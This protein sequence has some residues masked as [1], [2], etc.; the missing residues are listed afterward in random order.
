MRKLPPLGGENARPFSI[1]ERGDIV[2]FSDV[3]SGRTVAA[4]WKANGRT[5]NLGTLGGDEA[6]AFGINNDRV[7]VGFSLTAE[8]L[9]L[10]FV[11]TRESG[12]QPLPIK[13]VGGDQGEATAVNDNNEISGTIFR[14]DAPPL[15]VL[16]RPREDRVA[17]SSMDPEDAYTLTVTGVVEQRAVL[18]GVGGRCSTQESRITDQQLSV[19]TANARCA[20]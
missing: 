16:W 12:M 4:L 15:A 17:S 10:P 14:P 2:G 13:G 6:I 5:R 1:N 8:G 7:V 3:E 18:A 20:R 19:R 11:W 9:A